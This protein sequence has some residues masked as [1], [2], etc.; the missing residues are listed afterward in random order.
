MIT[1][2]E[3]LSYIKQVQQVLAFEAT[4]LEKFEALKSVYTGDS[5]PANKLKDEFMAK[6]RKERTLNVLNSNI[7]F[8]QKISIIGF[9]A[10]LT[11]RKWNPDY[12][13]ENEIRKN[14][15]TNKDLLGL[16][17]LGR[18]DMAIDDNF[19]FEVFY[20]YLSKFYAQHQKTQKGLNLSK[21]T[22]YDNGY[23]DFQYLKRYNDLNKIK[24][25]FDKKISNIAYNNRGTI[26]IDKYISIENPSN[27]RHEE[28]E[29]K[30]LNKLTEKEYSGIRTK[31]IQ[32]FE[33]LYE[34]SISKN[35]KVK[36]FIQ[37]EMPYQY[38]GRK[39]TITSLQ[40]S[41][42]SRLAYA[43]LGE[44][45]ITISESTHKDWNY[46]SKSWHNAHGPKITV[47][48]RYVNF[49][50]QGKQVTQVGVESFRGNYLINAIAKY[51]Q[52]KPIKT[53]KNIKKVQLSDY[54]EVRLIKKIG[55]TEV[56]T[57]SI[58]GN[59]V[60][61]CILQDNTTAHADTVGDA[62]KLWRKKVDAKFN[63]ENE[64]LTKQDA[65]ELGFC[66]AG[67]QSF[68]ED[69]GLDIEGAYPRKDL[70][71]IVIKKMELN[72]QKYANELAKIGINLNCK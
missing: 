29:C 3:K 45:C 7:E 63:F 57:R 35:E 34:E 20:G 62:V 51:L 12:E 22:R 58:A 65:Y 36:F 19:D 8:F 48:G 9:E 66:M 4:D 71:G 27:W 40:E 52:I 56:F 10:K 43:K 26:S 13:R 2:N 32:D 47:T 67:V 41:K 60:D 42:T 11:T 33:K 17:E 38:F 53:V 5:R 30:A 31:Y 37:T 64:M 69:N 70:R 61:Y 1:V 24:N 21:K 16:V 46:Y 6:V 23:I 28:Q 49:W 55:N 18:S 14:I 50:K 44:T 68:C 39:T 72:C 15:I 25:G 59:F 54:I